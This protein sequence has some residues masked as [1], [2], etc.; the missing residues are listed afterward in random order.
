M[1]SVKNSYL[2]IS[3]LKSLY[4]CHQN[5]C[6]CPSAE[7]DIRLNY[8]FHTGNEEVH[9]NLS[10][11]FRN[12]ALVYGLWFMY[13]G[14]SLFQTFVQR[15]GRYHC[16]QVIIT[17]LTIYSIFRHGHLF[18]VT[19]SGPFVWDTSPKS[20]DHNA[21]E[22]AIQ[23][24]GNIY[25][26]TAV[27]ICFVVYIF[28]YIIMK[29]S[30]CILQ[31]NSSIVWNDTMITNR[32]LTGSEGWSSWSQTKVDRR[33]RTASTCNTQLCQSHDKNFICFL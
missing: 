11:V 14:R 20:I 13:S 3:V 23:E 16:F 6:C 24:I 12:A 7:N 33:F 9:L 4:L 25:Q 27:C 21:W 26:A 5:T 18:L 29:V 22:E 15:E 30:E 32:I 31:K 8:I 2:D 19:W 17:L 28:R 1:L 10:T